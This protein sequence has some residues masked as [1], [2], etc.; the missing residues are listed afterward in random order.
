MKK[1][2][3]GSLMVLCQIL[4]LLM[5][6]KQ[7]K[8]QE[9][10]AFQKRGSVAETFQP[11]PFFEVVPLGWIKEQ[12]QD[13]LKGFT[14]HLDSLVP[15]LILRDDIYGKDRLS[16]HT[17]SKDV[18]AITE[19]A[20]LQAQFLWWNSETQSN[21]RDG[22]IR[23]AILTMDQP[24]IAR[25]KQYI[26]KM[27]STQDSDGYLG[28]YDKDLRYKFDNENGELWA[29]TTLLRGMLAW[30][31]FTRDFTILKAIE[32]CVNNVILNYPAYKS[33]PFHSVNP[34]AGGV[35]HGLAF[36]DILQELWRINGKPEY[37]DYCLFLYKDFSE[38][39]L[40]E[41]AQFMKLMDTTLPLKGHGVHTYEH[42]R[43]LA[44]AYYTSANPGLKTALKNFLGKIALETSASGGP[45]GD[46][47]IGGRKADATSRGYEYCSMHELLNSYTDLLAK[48]GE[49]D[50]GEMA[51]KLFFNAAQ[52]SRNPFESSIAYLKT[53][54]SYS[55]CGGLNGDT[56]VK[57]QTRYK[58][59]P[60]HQDVAVCCVPNAG[61]IAPYYVQSMWMKDGKALIAT[62][63]GPCEVET[64]IMGKRVNIE[65]QTAYPYDYKVTFVVTTHET[66]FDLKIRRP[67][68]ATKL[69]VSEEYREDKGYILIHKRWKGE[70]SVSI[71]FFP[72]AAVRQDINGEYFYTYGPLVLAR[73][74]Q[75][76]GIQTK[77]Y[78][79][80][81]FRDMHYRPLTTNVLEY[82]NE[83]V[84]QTKPGRLEFN[85]ALYNP[86]SRKNE[87]V[88]L[89]P[90][91][92]T[93]LR[94]V[95][96]KP[97]SEE[98]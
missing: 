18:G 12:I 55:M 37:R 77:T 84:K 8:A 54:N 76:I 1:L 23:S 13:N 81:E 85:T 26:L 94:Q 71:Q 97:K 72:E 83:G 65:E 25:A 17:K 28:I 43:S 3:A 19:N 49:A 42:L 33:H 52:G 2:A 86:V 34:D 67:S 48:T 95:T 47:W 56:T 44:A 57:T 36:T 90:M 45:A 58:Y 31:Y 59:S 11:L 16:R 70:E 29:K 92:Q 64:S 22:Y 62:L 91:G 6:A 96:F 74:L 89:I 75:S 53:D 98:K 46:E 39:V 20:E 82:A 93:I 14:G 88:I 32:S 80:K 61:R 50:F 66:E 60:V 87:P 73:P 79:L 5:P 24:H 35:T 38:A 15:D 40:N 10:D 68:W 21:W 51:E 27:L 4:C 30:Y 69:V 41:D 78:P 63:L 7:A 9:N